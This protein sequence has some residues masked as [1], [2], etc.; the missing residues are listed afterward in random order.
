MLIGVDCENIARFNYISPN[1]IKKVFTKKE[2]IY[3]Q[4][5]KNKA[6]HFAARFAAKEAVIKA[7]NGKEKMNFS[8]IEIINDK[9]GSPKVIILNAKERY[10]K[11]DINISLTHNDKIAIAFVVIQDKNG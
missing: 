1:F 6:Q 10:L 7:L 5:H 4:S 8:D 9:D 11:R 3:C 2:A